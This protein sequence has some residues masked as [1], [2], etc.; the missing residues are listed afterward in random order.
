VVVVAA[1]VAVAVISALR[2]DGGSATTTATIPKDGRPAAGAGQPGSAAPAFDLPGLRGGRVRL[3]D[4][5][6]R[7]VVLNFWASWCVPCRKEFPDLR[8]L[9]RQHR[10]DGLV[11]VGVTYRDLDGDARA[12]ARQ[13]RAT[14]PLA[15]GGRGDPV[16]EQYGVRF[17]PQTFFIAP[18]GTIV[19]RAFGALSG[20]RLRA[21]VAELLHS[22]QEKVRAASKG[23]PTAHTSRTT[24]SP[25][26]RLPAG[27]STPRTHS[28]SAAAGS[29]LA[30]T[31]SA[32]G[33]RLNG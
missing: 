31:S 13:Q 3:A 5:A 1:L 18:D 32:S 16:A 2:T 29:S 30:T 23:A 25:T 33:S 21:Q 17:V 8:A 22:S 27:S 12:F 7:P 14:W 28:A 9:A 10:A 19:A 24:S 11:V 20:D 15:S 4:Y 26:G 6:G